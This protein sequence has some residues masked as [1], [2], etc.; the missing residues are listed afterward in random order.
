M[1]PTP[2]TSKK[3]NISYQISTNTADIICCN[4]SVFLKVSSLEKTFHPNSQNNRSM[5]NLHLLKFRTC[6]VKERYPG[7]PSNG[8]QSS[9]CIHQNQKSINVLNLMQ[10]LIQVLGNLRQGT[11]KEKVLLKEGRR[12]FL[13]LFG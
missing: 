6:S 2:F 3:M 5:V 12:L 7:F 10:Q 11:N 8:L 1:L 13:L 9:R 4:T